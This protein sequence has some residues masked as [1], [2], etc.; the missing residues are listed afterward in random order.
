[1]ESHLKHL[2]KKYDLVIRYGPTHGEG[3]IVR[4]PDGYPNLIIVQDN[5]TDEETEKVSKNISKVI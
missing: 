1:M 4:T 3:Y 5:L 2:L